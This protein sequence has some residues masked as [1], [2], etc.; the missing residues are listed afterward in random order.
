MFRFLRA[1]ALLIV[2]A[3][4]RESTPAGPLVDDA[5]V[6]AT[7]AAPPLRVVS[8]IPATTEIVFALGAGSRLVGRTT[9]CDYP[10][11]AAAVP[12]LGNGIGPN[13]EAV[14]G[15]KP[16][17]VLLY[18]SASNRGAA[19][20]FRA[21]GIPTLELLTD[22]MADFDRVTRLIG[23]ALGREAV[24]DSL[25]AA[26]A[27]S[28]AAATVTGTADRPSVFI[29]SWDR[30]VITLGSGSFL[31]EIL[32]RAGAR[33]VFADLPTPSA[34]VSLEAVAARDPD[35]LLTTADGDPSIAS[36]PEWKSVRAVRE[37]RFLKVHGSEFN[38][39]SPRIADAV[40]QLAG[41]LAA[42]RP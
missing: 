24:A 14:V 25:V 4:C 18:K 35:F 41:A 33:N 17:L 23:R 10:A 22:R 31:S 19:E 8:L 38:R 34:P 29:L 11:A 37:R 2:V 5:G 16:D 40:R 3:A 21:L 15:A 27:R 7:F 1:I 20:R 36:A 28:L 30:P 12:D 13:I 39:P 42:L 32:E 9:W 26:T 6:A